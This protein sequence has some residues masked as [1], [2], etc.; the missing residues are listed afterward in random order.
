MNL[1]KN[2][3]YYRYCKDGENEGENDDTNHL[4][5]FLS[6]SKS[7][8]NIDDQKTDKKVGYGN[9]DQSGPKREQGSFTPERVKNPLTVTVTV[10]TVE[11]C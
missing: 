3:R 2:Y 6:G 10:F 4:R 7:L 11:S 5:C 9:T 1:K 8:E